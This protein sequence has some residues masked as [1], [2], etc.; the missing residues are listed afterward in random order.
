MEEG[1]GAGDD[2]RRDAETREE[3]EYMNSQ[4]SGFFVSAQPRC[5]DEA[6]NVKPGDK[7]YLPPEQRVRVW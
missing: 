5:L 2:S 7:L 4:N 1:R 3:S 6:L